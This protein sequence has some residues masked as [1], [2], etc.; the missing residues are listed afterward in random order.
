VIIFGGTDGATLT[1]DFSAAK[2]HC[3]GPREHFRG[4]KYF[5]E[6]SDGAYV[7]WAVNDKEVIIETDALGLV[8]YELW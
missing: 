6:F 3:S 4:Y 5:G 1:I 2:L 8:P 7:T